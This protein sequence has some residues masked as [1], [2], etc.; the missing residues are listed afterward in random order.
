MSLH[1]WIVFSIAS[2]AFMNPA[3][4]ETQGFEGMQSTGTLQISVSLNAAPT[5]TI[6]ITGLQDVS[7][8]KDAG[9]AAL[10]AVSRSACVYMSAPGTFKVDVT[11][12]P[13]TSGDTYYDYKITLSDNSGQNSV[14]VVVADQ[15]VTQTLANINASTTDGCGGT[16]PLQMMF[17]DEG[18]LDEAFTA[19]ATV[20]FLVVPD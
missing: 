4:A 1:H 20:S 6:K 19:Q 18:S 11:A 9:D 14:D 17:F 12:A 3:N 13:L 5:P 16:N 10:A 2:L 8:E 15:S 7:F